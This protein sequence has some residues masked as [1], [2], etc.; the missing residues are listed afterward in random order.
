M[1]FPD[2]FILFYLGIFV[3]TGFAN[4]IFMSNNKER[5]FN[6]DAFPSF[7]QKTSSVFVRIKIHFFMVIFAYLY[8][9]GTFCF[10]LPAS[11]IISDM[12]NVTNYLIELA[13]IVICFFINIFFLILLPSMYELVLN[14]FDNGVTQAITR[15]LNEKLGNTKH[16]NT[17]YDHAESSSHS[18]SHSSISSS[19]PT[20]QQKISSISINL[21]EVKNESK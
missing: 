10:A 13:N 7:Y 21:E 19:Q 11:I 5:Y 17:T 2:I 6:P 15:W 14:L 12:I 1:T 8:N 3:T 4:Y 20:I 18:S 9:F 16:I